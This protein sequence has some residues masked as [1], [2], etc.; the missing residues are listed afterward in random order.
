[1]V[2][3]DSLAKSYNEI[4]EEN[5]DKQYEEDGLV[6]FE[7]IDGELTVPIKFA[8]HVHV[9]SEDEEPLPEDEAARKWLAQGEFDTSDD[10][11]EVEDSQ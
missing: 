8:N 4:V 11:E 5:L 10:D 6:E 3:E 7:N 1:M 9:E 2:G